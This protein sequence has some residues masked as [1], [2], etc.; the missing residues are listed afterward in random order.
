MAKLAGEIVEFWVDAGPRRWF[1]RDYDFD[2]EIRR[3]FENVHWEAARGEHWS[4]GTEARG[5]LALLLLLD[6]FP[7][8]MYRGTADAFTTDPLARAVTEDALGA[9]FDRQ[10]TLE[11][12]PFFYLPFEHDENPTSQAEAVA[13]FQ[14]YVERGGDESYLRYARLHA[15]LIKRFGRFPHRNLAMGR[16]STPDELAYLANGGFQG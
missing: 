4:W 14:A 6:Q 2:A 3:L 12:Q 13:R 15:D 11:L 5:A 7:R 9:A 10:L 8:N 1:R 16:E